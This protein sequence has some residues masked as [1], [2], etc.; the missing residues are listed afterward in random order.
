M[1]PIGE[2]GFPKE[3]SV[4]S[5]QPLIEGRA[6]LIGF[7]A[8]G[9][10]LA[11]APLSSVAMLLSVSLLV[12]A[13]ILERAGSWRRWLRM[14]GHVK[15]LLVMM[16]VVH[17]VATPGT[18]ILP[19]LPGVSEIGLAKG[20]EQVVRV[21]GMTTAAWMLLQLSDASTLL[22]SLNSVFRPLKR[23]GIPVDHLFGLTLFA[24]LRIPEMYRI[25][26]RIRETHR[27]RDG[28]RQPADGG[29]LL[30]IRD[31][32]HRVARLADTL[33]M[34]LAQ[35]VERQEQRLATL[36]VSGPL[37]PFQVPARTPWTI[38]DRLVAGIPVA[39]LLM[40]WADVL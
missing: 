34:H 15:W 3:C 2:S 18:P 6:L 30:S 25:G 35:H 22:Q 13:M 38:Q 14:V 31:R 29:V 5:N 33:L 37:P 12:A 1:S 10:L 40:V 20:S 24:L 27:L 8:T 4:Q 19:W 36:G 21:V 9:T 26:Y 11:A 7:L 17:A 16:I 32:L 23:V 28:R 39:L